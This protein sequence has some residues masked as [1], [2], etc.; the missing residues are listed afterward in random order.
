MTAPNYD[1]AIVGYGP[2]GAAL[3][4]L[5]GSR[6]HS[7]LVIDQMREIYDK[8]RAI[9]IDH[10][11]MRVLQSVG[12][13]D[14]VNARA[15]PYAGTDFLGLD[16]RPIKVFE[17]TI[18]PYPLHWSPNLLFIQ[19]EFEP[20]LRG[21]VDR[22]ANVDVLL[23]HRATEV[24]QTPSAAG[25]RFV[26]DDGKIREATARYL[27]ACDGAASP[28]RKQLGVGQESLNFDEWWTVVDAWLMRPTPLPPRTT[29][30]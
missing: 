9:N 19:P 3:A 26:A 11:V 6:G 4:N 5:L 18:P 12:L 21:G 20:I 10:E 16:G 17:P 2:V 29:Q 15:I 23:E 1:V 22:F 25:V 30:Y 27:V 14:A 8:P 24:W 28:I 7:V 13:A